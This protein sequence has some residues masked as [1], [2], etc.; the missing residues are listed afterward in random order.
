MDRNN[1]LAA[2]EELQAK[3]LSKI[4][5]R[6]LGK[7]QYPKELFKKSISQLFKDEEE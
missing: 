4:D 2:D 5:L 1:R 3:I 6:L 7:K